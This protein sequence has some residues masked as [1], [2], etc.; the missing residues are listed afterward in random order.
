VRV[1][2]EVDDVVEVCV[3]VCDVVRIFYA[4]GGDACGGY[5]CG[6]GDDD[7]DAWLNRILPNILG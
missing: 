5:A 6:G 7:D 2:V 4:C 1:C 3:E